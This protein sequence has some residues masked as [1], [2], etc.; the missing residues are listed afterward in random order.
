[1]APGWHRIRQAESCTNWSQETLL[2][3]RFGEA[4][5]AAGCRQANH[6]EEGRVSVARLRHEGTLHMGVLRGQRP[7]PN[8][9]RKT[10]A[11][12]PM[13]GARRAGHPRARGRHVN[14]PHGNRLRYETV[15]E[16]SR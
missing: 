7:G 8:V 15:V 13:D 5:S 10:L 14:R 1:M 6:A 16:R 11:T 12:S 9:G 4:P 2:Q 3:L